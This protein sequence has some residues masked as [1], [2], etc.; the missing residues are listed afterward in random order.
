LDSIEKY[1]LASHLKEFTINQ[2]NEIFSINP[3]LIKKLVESAKTEQKKED[4]TFFQKTLTS[5][6]SKEIENLSEAK[7][8]LNVISSQIKSATGPNRS[9]AY[10]HAKNLY[11]SWRGFGRRNSLFN[12]LV[13]EFTN[14]F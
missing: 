7:E 9:T 12:S 11:V 1:K 13:N 5:Y 8:K 2:A 4:L 6:K 10:L 3:K 14:L